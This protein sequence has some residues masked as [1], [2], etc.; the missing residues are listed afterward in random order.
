MLHRTTGQFFNE[1]NDDNSPKNRKLTESVWLTEK[2][3]YKI[4]SQN[5]Q[6]GITTGPRSNRIIRFG[7]RVMSGRGH[8]L[9]QP[10]LEIQVPRADG[11]NDTKLVKLNI[12]KFSEEPEVADLILKLL[13]SNDQYFTDANGVRTN[14]ENKHLLDFIVNIGP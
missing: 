12:K 7:S 11:G 14:I 13:L 1:K 4:N 6:I 8:Y 9:G 3:P 10:M 2:D 5:T